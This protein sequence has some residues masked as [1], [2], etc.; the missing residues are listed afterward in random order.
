MD[1]SE[2]MQFQDAIREKRIVGC[3]TMSGARF[4]VKSVNWKRGDLVAYATMS[5]KTTA[6]A[7]KIKSMQTLEN[8]R[9]AQ[10][11]LL[12]KQEEK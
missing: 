6:I 8:V 7:D 1:N 11:F 5:D 4:L 10:S 3:E 2:I 12:K 9:E